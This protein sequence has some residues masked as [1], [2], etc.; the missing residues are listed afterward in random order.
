M[1][2][3]HHGLAVAGRRPGSRAGLL[4]FRLAHLG[5]GCMAVAGLLVPP[6]LSAGMLPRPDELALP[7]GSEQT[8]LGEGLRLYGMPAD[9]RL[10]DIPLPVAD[11][12]PLLT[13]RHPSLSDL[14]VYPGRAVLSGRVGADLWVIMLEPAGPRRS[15]G[16][17]SVLGGKPDTSRASPGRRLGM[18]AGARLRLDFAAREQGGQVTHQVWTLALPL[19]AARRAV[20]DGL[21]RAGWR[22]DAARPEPQHW[23][24]GAARL[25]VSIVEADGGSG[26]LVQHHGAGEP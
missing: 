26:I 12:V 23:V 8:S 11:A 6:A 17:I 20:D 10:L 25:V 19:S 9:I 24:R 15:R 2:A 5:G 3:P 13:A 18:P 22:R 14:G 7:P 1:R 16:S 4:R 21:R